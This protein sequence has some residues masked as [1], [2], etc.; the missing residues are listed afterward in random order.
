[1]FRERSQLYR[2]RSQ[3]SIKKFFKIRICIWIV[4]SGVIEYCDVCWY[5][6]YKLFESSAY[7]LDVVVLR[8]VC[9]TAISRVLPASVSRGNRITC[10]P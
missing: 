1:M 7:G 5:D 2:E 8:V 9:S 3:L 4:I 6:F 10:Y